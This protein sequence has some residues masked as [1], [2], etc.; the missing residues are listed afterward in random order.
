[1]KLVF[2]V[3]ALLTLVWVIRLPYQ[4]ITHP[5][6][7]LAPREPQQ[8]PLIEGA[9]MIQ[10]KGWNLKPLA[11]YSLQAR[12]LAVKRYRSDPTADLSPYDVLLGWGPM[13]D[14]ANLSEI[15]FSQRHRFGYWHHGPNLSISASEISRHQANTHLIPANAEIQSRMSWL[16][17]GSVVIIRG[18]LV[19]A[20]RVDGGGPPWRSSVTRADT[21]DGACEIVYVASLVIK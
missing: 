20:Q 16:R 3:F 6:G 19:E 13:S 17:E 2:F 7:V 21:G 9:P 11:T 1:M 10:L 18:H 15:S 14:S 12:V 5:P 8:G 4:P